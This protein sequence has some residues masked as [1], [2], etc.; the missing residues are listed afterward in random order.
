[1]ARGPAEKDKRVS[2]DYSLPNSNDPLMGDGH[3]QGYAASDEQRARVLRSARAYSRFVRT[4]KFLL[5]LSAFAVLAITLLL[6]LFYDADDTLTF[7]FSSVEQVDNDL[8]MVNPRF[9]GLDEENRPFLVT[10]SSAIQDAADPR[11]VTLETLEADMSLSETTWVNLRAASGHLDTE[12]E[13][14]VLEGDISLFT[15]AGY[16]FHTQRALVMLSERRV[17]SETEVTGQ[18]P[19]GSLRA[20]GFEAENAGE[21][22]RFTGNVRMRIYPPGSET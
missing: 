15:D 11:T 2:S 4:M 10:A 21:I 22:L 18:G 7:S 12:S 5:P 9:S 8:R 3:R 1:M 14:L 6:A 17:I 16:E 20:D 19:L 13:T